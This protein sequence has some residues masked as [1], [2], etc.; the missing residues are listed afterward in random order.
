MN[1]GSFNL[2]IMSPLRRPQNDSDEQ[3]DDH[4]EPNRDSGNGDHH[5]DRTGKGDDRSDGEIDAARDNGE[6]YTDAH[7][8]YR[9]GLQGES[10]DASHGEEILRRY[11]EKDKQHDNRDKRKK[12][13]QES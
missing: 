11:R 7:E 3:A 5:G 1:G 6:G 9:A 12:S 10:E 4:A 13:R 2:V 8:G